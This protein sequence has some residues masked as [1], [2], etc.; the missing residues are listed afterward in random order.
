MCMG[1]HEMKPKRELARVVRNKEGEISVDLIGKKPGRGAY[2]CKNQ[3]C[4]EKAIKTRKL[5]KEFSSKIP[6]EVYT[7]LR[8][9][10]EGV[11]DGG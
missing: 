6:E 9:Q 10:M 1:C 8:Q 7:E 5:E 2:V 4:L 3:E 11:N